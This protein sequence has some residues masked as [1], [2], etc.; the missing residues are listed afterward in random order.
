[1]TLIP[2]GPALTATVRGISVWG[3]GLPGW[4]ASRPILAGQTPYLPAETTAPPVAM[5]SATERRRAGTMVRLALAVA[6][7]AADMAGLAADSLPVIFGS[8]CAD[9]VI[10]GSILETLAS[11]DHQ[12]SP[13]LFHNSV[14]NAPAGYW[15]ICA[16]SHRPVT[17]L[18]ADLATFPAAL[19][20]A[21]IQVQID[22]EPVLVCIY[23]LP[24]P[25]PLLATRPSRA[26]FGF[27]LVLAPPA[28]GQGPLLTVRHEA[29]ASDDRW[30]PKL[31]ALAALSR[32]NPATRGLAL[33]EAL[34]GE[35]TT[36]LTIPYLEGRLDLDLRPC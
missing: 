10:I 6:Q 29:T 14:H 35:A 24:L 28:A 23:D 1:M 27:A 25:P 5:L 33:L 2:S 13:T 4:A 9:G 19:L 8:A 30:E 17:S 11:H 32:D 7:Q 20:Q 26:T 16:K 21:M 18:G 15:T 34:A 22:Q 3:P 36:R 31:P 12:I